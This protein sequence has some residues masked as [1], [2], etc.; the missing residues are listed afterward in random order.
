MIIALRRERGRIDKL[1]DIS[2]A[3]ILLWFCRVSRSH[4]SYLLF[5]FEWVFS[6]LHVSS[7]S[8]CCVYLLDP[9]PLVKI[10]LN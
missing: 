2:R 8:V 5:P 9:C 3:F 7:G 6:M 10:R 4:E 1:Y